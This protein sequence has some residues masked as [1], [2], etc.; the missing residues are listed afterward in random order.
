MLILNMQ[1]DFKNFNFLEKFCPKN[2]VRVLIL[3]NFGHGKFQFYPTMLSFIFGQCMFHM[4]ENN[5]W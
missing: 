1:S 2:G 4:D 5:F 3:K